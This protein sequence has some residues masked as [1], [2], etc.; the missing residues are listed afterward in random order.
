MVIDTGHVHVGY[1]RW[2]SLFPTNSHLLCRRSG[3]HRLSSAQAGFGVGQ[4]SLSALWERRPRI[5]PPCETHALHP[6]VVLTFRQTRA[7]NT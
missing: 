7:P 6:M 3:V 4:L 2:V 1:P 5:V